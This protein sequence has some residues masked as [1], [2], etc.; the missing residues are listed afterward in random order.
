MVLEALIDLKWRF[1]Q[2][3]ICQ[4]F[5]KYG[6]FKIVCC[7]VTTIAIWH[8]LAY[9]ALNVEA[10]TPIDILKVFMLAV[11]VCGWFALRALGKSNSKHKEEL[12][13]SESERVKRQSKLDESGMP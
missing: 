13:C 9:Q 8:N 5:N 1:E 4:I 6:S 3:K 12:K 10:V 11:I 7:D 2:E